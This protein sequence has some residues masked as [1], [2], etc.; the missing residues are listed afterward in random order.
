MGRMGFMHQTNTEGNEH[1][2]A[3]ASTKARQKHRFSFESYSLLDD[4]F[5]HDNLKGL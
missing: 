3:A 2:F 5:F 4:N 1:R